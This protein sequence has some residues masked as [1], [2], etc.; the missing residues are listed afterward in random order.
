MEKILAGSTSHF[1]YE[2]LQKHG[3]I[4]IEYIWGM[5]FFLFLSLRLIYFNFIMAEIKK[6]KTTFKKTAGLNFAE[7]KWALK[8][9]MV[10]MSLFSKLEMLTLIQYI[11]YNLTHKTMKEKQV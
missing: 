5:T 9:N 10:Y 1:S 2:N 3:L 8:K 7:K 11:D 6:N 4:F